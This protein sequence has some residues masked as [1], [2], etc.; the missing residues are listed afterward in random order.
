MKRFF[1]FLTDYWQIPLLVVGGV[2]AFL[3]LRD[4]RT[5][6]KAL[7]K[8]TRELA[9]VAAKRET[10]EIELQMGAEQARQHVRDKYTALRGKLDAEAE[11]KAKELEDDPVALTA[12]LERASR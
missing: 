6:G 3:F 1:Q 12:F 2:L 5:S 11:L 9:A 7:G 4:R 8:V 10:R